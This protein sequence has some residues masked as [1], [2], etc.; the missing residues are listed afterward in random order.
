METEVLERD[1][2][3]IISIK[4]LRE[5]W[6]Q[7]PDA[8]KPLRAWHQVAEKASWQS[9]VD[10]RD[11]Y[12]HAD[13]VGGCLVFNIGGNRFR[14]VVTVRFEYGKMYIRSVMTHAEYN[15]MTWKEECLCKD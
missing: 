8:E 6:E 13:K 7:F 3:H 1:A 2:M 9:I 11:T 12:P 4:R 5:F 15:R 14:L 10:V